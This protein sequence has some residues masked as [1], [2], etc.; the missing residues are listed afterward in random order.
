MVRGVRRS[1]GWSHSDI[2]PSLQ[3]PV[4][5]CLSNRHGLLMWPNTTKSLSQNPEVDTGLSVF[6]C[7]VFSRHGFS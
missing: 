6:P 5:P 1:L 3:F 7:R 2:Q 4:L